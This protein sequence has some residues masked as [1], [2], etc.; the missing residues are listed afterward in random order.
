MLL[1]GCQEQRLFH[2]LFLFD[3]GSDDHNLL[4]VNR[5]RKAFE[6]AL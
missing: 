2:S 6:G 3:P 4:P 1:E 5:K